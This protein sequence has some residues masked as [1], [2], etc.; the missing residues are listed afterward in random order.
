L[1]KKTDIKEPK[2]WINED[3][4]L[5]IERRKKV[6]SKMNNIFLR[7]RMPR[8]TKLALL[9]GAFLKDVAL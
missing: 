7:T 5:V 8:T 1:L 3:I 9:T 4:Y 6:M 2:L